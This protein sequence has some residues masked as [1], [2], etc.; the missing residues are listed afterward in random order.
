M[1]EELSPSYTILALETSCDETAAAVIRGG[2]TII[3]NEVASQMHLHERYGGV[4]PEVA[5]REHILSMAPVVEAAIAPL[6]GGWAEVDAVACT[7]GP[8]LA[9]ALLTGVNAAKGLAWAHGLPLV[10]VNHLEAHIYANWLHPTGTEPAGHDDPPFPLVCLI[11]SGGHT[12]LVLLRDHGDYRLL[13]QTRD[14]AA[15]EA[16]DKAARIMGLGYPGGPRVEQIARGVDPEGMRVPRAWLGDSYDFSFSGVKTHVLHA[17]AEQ[18][19]APPDPRFAPRL[20][21]AFQDAVVDVLVSKTVRAAEEFGASCVLL[22][23]GVAANGPLRDTLIARSPVPVRYPPIRLCTD[24]AAMVGAA[25]FFRY[26]E[27]L[28]HDWSLGIRPNLKVV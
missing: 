17:V 16:F 26:R 12:T 24:N 15:G 10:A 22:A 7:Y 27:G 11:V 5:S 1:V 6:P 4:V 2:R 25:A 21:A 28:Q 3:S 13:G 9:G 19:S 14:D 8:G 18:E 23:G 20:A